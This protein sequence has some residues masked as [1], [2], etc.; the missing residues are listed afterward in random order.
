MKISIVTISYNQARF[1]R[2]TIESVLSQEGVDVEYIV[3][4]GGSTDG[5]GD[6]LREYSDRF[7]NLIVRPDG[8]PAHGLNLGFHS[9]TGDI[10]GYLNS[11]DL[12]LPGT[13]RHVVELFEQQQEV[14]VLY[15]DGILIDAGGRRRGTL[16][17]SP[18]DVYKVALSAYHVVQPSTF[19][20]RESFR[21]AGGFNE[22]NPSC[23]DRELLVDLAL[24]GARF[25][26]VAAPWAAFRLHGESITGSRRHADI[27]KIQHQRIVVKAFG[28]PPVPADTVR[29]LLFRCQRRLLQP[30]VLL[31]DWQ[32]LVQRPLP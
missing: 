25:Q 4:D 8:G 24:S 10:F 17:S 20:R 11:D 30:A 7:A 23:W 21:R 26:H 18:W 12:L 9:A 3:V 32:R 6:I 31:T 1:L 15:G 13:L 28:R 2:Q 27:N 22:Q 5:S 16:L 14:D 29:R 19:M